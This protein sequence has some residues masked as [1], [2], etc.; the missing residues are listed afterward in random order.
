MAVVKCKC[1]NTY[2]AKVAVNQFRDNS[3][4][5]HTSM[6]EVDV[7]RDIKIYQ[8]MNSECGKYMM[9]PLNY[10]GSTEND[11]E[12]YAIIEAALEGKVLEPKSKLRPKS[13]HPGTARFLE[14]EKDTVGAG[15]FTPVE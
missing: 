7:D 1:G 12:L 10:Y 13:L 11:K 14:K 9:P 6:H 15:T 8:C 2:Y 3:V 4:N 5:L